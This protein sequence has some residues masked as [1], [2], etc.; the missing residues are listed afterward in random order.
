MIANPTAPSTHDA[1]K[2]T[3]PVRLESVLSGWIATIP[4][5]AE[6]KER[7]AEF[8]TNKQL[9]LSASVKADSVA[10]DMVWGFTCIGR[11]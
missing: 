5:W 6:S 1:V 2:V 3:Y 8:D 10:A 4:G 9:C 7:P 11:L